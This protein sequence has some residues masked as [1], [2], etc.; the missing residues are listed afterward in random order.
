L[1]TLVAA[2]IHAFS[3]LRWNF[4]SLLRL[5]GTLHMLKGA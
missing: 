1:F 2:V 3:G 5:I 4:C